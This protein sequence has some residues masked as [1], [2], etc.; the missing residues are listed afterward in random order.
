MAVQGE[1]MIGDLEA[2]ALCDRPLALLDILV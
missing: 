1:R 2:Q